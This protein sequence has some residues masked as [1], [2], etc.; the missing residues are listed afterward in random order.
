MKVQGVPGALDLG[1]ARYLSDPLKERCLVSL[2]T[3]AD[4]FASENRHTTEG[5]PCRVI[6]EQH[7]DSVDDPFAVL[8]K[9]ALH[10]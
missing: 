2:R 3:V 1:Y 5:L 9:N 7:D 6:G 8:E 4:A 10:L